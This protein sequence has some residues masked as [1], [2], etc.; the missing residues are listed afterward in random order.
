MITKIG[1]TWLQYLFIWLTW[2]TVTVA[3]QSTQRAEAKSPVSGVDDPSL[4]RP[5]TPLSRCL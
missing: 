5:S 4:E 2:P 3:V 1:Q